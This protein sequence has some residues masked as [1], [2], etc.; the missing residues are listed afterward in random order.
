MA[1]IPDDERGE[2]V[3]AWIILK[4]GYVAGDE[5]AAE[6]QQHTKTATAPYKYPRAIE[7]VSDLPKTV[8]GKIRRNVLRESGKK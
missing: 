6:L 2:L 3:K 1:G 4:A 5:L 8:T 7:F